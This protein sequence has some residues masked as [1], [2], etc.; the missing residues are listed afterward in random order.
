ML[1]IGELKEILSVWT[2]DTPIA[3]SVD[4]KSKPKDVKR[5]GTVL[6]N[7]YEDPNILS[8]CAGLFLWTDEEK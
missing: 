4:S 3:V 2:D 8:A 5:V 7:R 6:V 1:T